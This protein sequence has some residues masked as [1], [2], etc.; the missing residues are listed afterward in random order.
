LYGGR[1]RPRTWDPLIE[2]VCFRMKL[3]G[4][5]DKRIVQRTLSPQW[6]FILLE[7]LGRS[8]LGH[9][10]GCRW[11]EPLVRYIARPTISDVLFLV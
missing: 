9:L 7:R 11:F 4:D 3:R 1:T 6:V 8:P 2:S 10:I 5:S